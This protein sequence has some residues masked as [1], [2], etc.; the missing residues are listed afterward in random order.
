[1]NNFRIKHPFRG[2]VIIYHTISNADIEAAVD[3]FQI[4][5][6]ATTN[7]AANASIAARAKKTKQRKIRE[8]TDLKRSPM[9]NDIR[10]IETDCQCYTCRNFSRSYIHHLFKAKESSFPV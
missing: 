10:P 8:H 3:A 2:T 9:R 1:M 7:A 5:Y 6:E 4:Q